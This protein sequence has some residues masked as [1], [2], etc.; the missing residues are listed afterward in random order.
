MAASCGFGPPESVR[1]TIASDG[2]YYLD[3]APVDS[4]ELVHRLREMHKEDPNLEVEVRAS[5]HASVQSIKAAIEAIQSS[6]VKFV[7]VEAVSPAESE[8]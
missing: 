4:V 5:E 2:S 1:L 6:G 3:R 8:T 7:D